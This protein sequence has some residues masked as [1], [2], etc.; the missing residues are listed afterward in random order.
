[1]RLLPLLFVLLLLASLPAAAGEMIAYFFD[2]GQG[3]AILLQGPDFTVLIDAGRHDRRDVVSHLERV[4]VEV[5]DL[6]VGT[7]PHADH[8]GQCEAVVRQFT[9]VEVWMSGN[10]H[11]SATYQRC[12]AA[13][14]ET[15]AGYYEPRAGDVFA[16]GDLRLEVLHPGELSGD[17]NNDSI[18]IRAIYHNVA[19]LLTG[20]A[21]ALAEEA[22]LEREYDLSAQVLKVG[23]HGSRTSTS[24]SFVQAIDPDIAIY[25]AGLG[26]SYGHPHEET[27]SL[28]RQL[29]IPVFG[30]DLLGTIVVYTDGYQYTVTPM[31]D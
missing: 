6:F 20:D 23:H 28:L 31:R 18:V 17:L 29:G 4:G 15:E 3:D 14:M 13:I 24:R 22:I 19:I 16:I 9:V 7:H 1:M 11:T 5:I 8:I 2:V 25:S 30:T 21:E 26:N 27:I 10:G 12:I